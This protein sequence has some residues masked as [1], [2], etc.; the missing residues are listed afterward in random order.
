MAEAVDDI[1]TGAPR[2]Q[3]A[4]ADLPGQAPRRPVQDGLAVKADQGDVGGREPR[5]VQ[6]RPD[7]A[8][9]SLGG[10]PLGLADGMRHRRAAFGVANGAGILQ[11]PAQQG[12]GFAVIGQRQAGAGADDRLAIGLEQGGIDAVQRG[13][14]HQ[15]DDFLYSR[16]LCYFPSPFDRLRVRPI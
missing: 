2:Q 1:D 12:A 14:A 5:L 6:Q 9:V 13:A 3:G 10:K 15:A 11:R 16:H 4:V 7:G 8:G